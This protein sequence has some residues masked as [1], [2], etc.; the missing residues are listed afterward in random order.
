MFSRLKSDVNRQNVEVDQRQ[1]NHRANLDVAL[2]REQDE[3]QHLHHQH[4]DSEELIE[5]AP[6]VILVAHE[7]VGKLVLE[8][9]P[10]QKRTFQ[11][12]LLQK[13]SPLQEE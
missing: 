13:E 10:H 6:R 5:I 1:G 7:K 11:H 4:E 12:E 9:G 2:I 8:V 3:E